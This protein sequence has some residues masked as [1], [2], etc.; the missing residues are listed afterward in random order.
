M[1]EYYDN[2]FL[3]IFAA[4]AVSCYVRFLQ[5]RNGNPHRN[6]P[7]ELP[8]RGPDKRIGSIRL[9]NYADYSNDLEPAKALAW[10][11]QESLLA[12]RLLSY[13]YRNLAWSYRKVSLG[14][15]GP[16]RA[17][18]DF[19]ERKSLAELLRQRFHC[20]PI[21]YWKDLVESYS[22]RGHTLPKDKFPAM[23]GMAQKYG[24][25]MAQ[26]VMNEEYWP[27]SIRI[28]P[29]LKAIDNLQPKYVE[30]NRHVNNI[31]GGAEVPRLNY[32]AGIWYFQPGVPRFPQIIHEQLFWTMPLLEFSSP[33]VNDL[34]RKYSS[35]LSGSFVRRFREYI[36][37][38]WSWA[39]IDGPIL[40]EDLGRNM[41]VARDFEFVD[42]GVPA[43]IPQGL[44]GALTSGFLT[45]R[46]RMREVPTAHEP[47]EPSIVYRPDAE[48]DAIDLE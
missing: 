2:A 17:W 24:Q 25:I 3:C 28:E 1:S 5:P 34:T 19:L 43:E 20:G 32:L 39:A 26:Y 31:D 35:Q 22:T 4:A 18:H 42:I 36:A 11:M 33:P 46:G 29:Q 47:G 16:Y 8:Y 15:G 38:S 48:D 41:R 27:R 13:S 40:Y 37:P 45:V 14:D 21:K 44:Y 7:F 9:V 12:P 23:S 30:T 10:I 6:G